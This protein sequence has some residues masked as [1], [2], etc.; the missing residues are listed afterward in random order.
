MDNRSWKQTGKGQYELQEQ[1]YDE[2]LNHESKASRKT[3][4]GKGLF[5]VFG[6]ILGAIIS[7]AVFF[8]F[9]HSPNSLSREA[10]NKIGTLEKLIDAHYLWER[11]EKAEEDGVYKGLVSSLGDKYAY[12]YTEEELKLDRENT[13]GEF[14]GIGCT[15]GNDTELGMCYIAGVMPGYSA[16][17]A[18]IMVG[19]Y[20]IEVDGEDATNWTSAEVASHVKGPEG[21]T[22]NIKM[23]R[24]DEELEFT[25]ERVKVESETVTYEMYDEANKIGYIRILE[26]DAI[27]VTQFKDA[28]ED[29]TKQG[30]EGLIL[31]LRSNPGGLVNACADIASELLPKGKIAYALSKDGKKIEWNCD[32]KNE[33]KIPVVILVNGGSASAAE[34][35]TGAMK[36]HEKATVLGTTTYGK[37]IIQNTY[38]L[39]DGTAVEFTAGEYYLPKGE[40]IHERGIDPDIEL[41]LDKEAYLKDGSD[42]QLEAAGKE[43]LKQL[44]K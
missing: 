16:E 44:G 3:T 30:M 41:D 42:N 21:T 20:F 23:L 19:D 26:F 8:S 37:G 10:Q 15:I 17:Q 43:M 6:L 27:T 32:G 31:D 9:Y 25:V 2:S 4:G 1:A 5:F 35:L 36:D 13:A 12:Y 28:K 34:I 22:V 38:S 33:I 24:K 7:A 39:G 11:D 40:C 29:L 18:G 14:T